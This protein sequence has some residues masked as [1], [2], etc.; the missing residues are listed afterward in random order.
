MDKA[1][2]QSGHRAEERN[3]AKLKGQR[4]KSQIQKKRVKKERNLLQAGKGA[5]RELKRSV[6]AQ[7]LGSYL[8]S[9]REGSS[10]KTRRAQDTEHYSCCSPLP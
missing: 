3:P 10:P 4:A 9:R 8:Q 7:V 2:Q 1:T 6:P 5:R